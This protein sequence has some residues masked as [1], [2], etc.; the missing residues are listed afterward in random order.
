M[1]IPA[2]LPLAAVLVTLC[3]ALCVPALAAVQAAPLRIELL[4]S[5]RLTR[6]DVRLGDVAAISTGDLAL[7]RRLM[8]LPLGPA[9]RAGDSAQLS[10]TELMRWIHARTGIAGRDVS[11]QGAQVTQLQRASADIAGDQLVAAAADSLRGWLAGRSTRADITPQAPPRDLAVPYGQ[12]VLRARSLPA[13]QPLSRRMLVWVDV[14]VDDRFVRTV[15]VGF[16]VQ[17]FGPAHV[18]THDMPAGSRVDEAALQLREVELTGLGAAP[19][20]LPAVAPAQLRHALAAGQPVTR[21][22]IQAQPA[23]ARG[24]WVA[25]RVRSGG[26]ELESR[27][28]ALQNGRVGQ[29]VSVKP[30]NAAAPITARVVAPGQVEVVQ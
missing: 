20:A 24:D 18:A 5:V 30:G 1:S 3:A 9:P 4:S 26:I 19:L 23:I 21:Q 13:Q 2:R 14:W 10:R 22:D 28:E 27:V 7:L 6:A 17:A 8:A 25:L 29:L 12:T 15:P 11:W 16:E